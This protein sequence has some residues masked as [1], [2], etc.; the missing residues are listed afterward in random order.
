MFIV[1]I[2]VQIEI[3]IRLPRSI[4]RFYDCTLQGVV[5]YVYCVSMYVY[6]HILICIANALNPFCVT[7]AVFT[8]IQYTYRFMAMLHLRT[9]FP[10]SGSNPL[11]IMRA[12]L[13]ALL[14]NMFARNCFY[15]EFEFKVGWLLLRDMMNVCLRTSFSCYFAFWFEFPRV[16]SLFLLGNWPFFRFV[17]V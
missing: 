16:S 4:F 14:L 8:L 12:T 3:I 15:F 10:Y 2:Y 7:V 9:A 17:R 6:E 13:T 11:S 5:V 1:Y